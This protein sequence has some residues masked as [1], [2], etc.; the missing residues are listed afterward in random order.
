METLRGDLVA[1]L[2]DLVLA[3]SPSTRPET[4]HRAIDLLDDAFR[5]LE[6]ATRDTVWP[7]G[8]LVEMP[9]VVRG[10]IARGPGVFDMKGGLAQI[11]FALR[12]LRDLGLD[13]PVTPVVLVNTDEEIGS[14]ESGPSIRR[15]ARR[16]ERAYVMEPA[17]GL[18][19][20]I[21]TGRKGLGRFE[22]RVQGKSGHGGDPDV[23]ASA[24]LELSHVI[25]RLY[26]LKDTARGISVNVGVVE[27]G[28][29]PNVVAPKSR[30]I[31]DV[32]LRHAEDIP[33]IEEEIRS[34]QPV[35]PGT[36]IRIEGGVHRLPLDRN[37][38]NRA[39]WE[40]ARET[41]HEFGLKLE[42]GFA[43]GASDGNTT[44]LYTA[45]LDGLGAVGSGAHGRHEFV[46]VDR[47]VERAALLAALV[48]LPVE[49]TRPR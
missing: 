36:S 14:P 37:P 31:V 43:G 39:L 11:V 3:E 16:A 22:V 10:D 28:I 46:Y 12:S 47:L 8:M 2:R 34:I 9:M 19:G 25:Q 24:I 48:L 18:S 42:E 35:T 15:L 30:A 38:R 40:A 7:V 4:Q 17:L 21:K 13:P 5:A 32:R 23:G 27:G 44:S 1:F 45:T 49:R 29:R 6:Y 33:W 26:D 20:K 41:A